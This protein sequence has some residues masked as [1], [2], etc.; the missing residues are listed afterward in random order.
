MLD[1]YFISMSQY[2][3]FSRSSDNTHNELC[4][5]LQDLRQPAV[6]V[7]VRLGLDPGPEPG[8]RD[9]LL[10]GADQPLLRPHLQQRGPQDA[11]A[12][13]AGRAADQHAGHRVLPPPRPGAHPLRHQETAQTLAHTGTVTILVL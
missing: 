11:E 9:G 12:G 8:Q 4:G 3:T 1:M 10:H 6:R 13:G 2:S 5:E 7:V